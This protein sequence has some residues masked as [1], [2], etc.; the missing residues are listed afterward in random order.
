[1]GHVHL[2]AHRLLSPRCK[3]QTLHRNPADSTWKGKEK[4]ASGTW[5][6]LKGQYPWFDCKSTNSDS[7]GTAQAT[8]S[9]VYCGEGFGLLKHKTIQIHHITKDKQFLLNTPA[10]KPQGW[11]KAALWCCIWGSHEQL[12]VAARGWSCSGYCAG[13]T[14]KP[15]HPQRSGYGWL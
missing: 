9:L 2:P 6:W 7:T 3:C 10:A 8:D 4:S 1:M 11:A 15:C 14:G 5:M 12:W 13:Q